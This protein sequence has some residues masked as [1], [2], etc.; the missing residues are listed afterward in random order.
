MVDVLLIFPP[1]S[2]NERYAK[3][4]GDVGG[5]LPPLGL[6]TIAAVLEENG[7]S[8][9][10][11]DGPVSGLD[12]RGV[13]KLA[14]KK[15]PGIIG[16]SFLTASVYRAEELAKYLKKSMPDTPVIVGGHHTTIL[17]KEVAKNKHFDAGV[18]GE[19]EFTFL[20]L[21]QKYKENPKLFKQPDELLKIQG[22]VVKVKGKVKFSGTRPPISDL[23]ALPF[24]ARHLVD[25]KKYVPLPNQYL[26]KPITNMVAIRGCPYQCTYC[27]NSAIFG[28]KI[29]FPSPERTVSEMEHLIDDYGIREISFW[30][31]TFT[32]NKEW[33]HKVCDLI[34]KKKFDIIWSCYGRVNTVDLKLLRKMKKAGCWNIFYGLEAGDQKLLD[35]INK[36]ITLQQI[37]NAI[38]WTKQ[39]GIE[40]RGSFMLALPGETPE[41]ARKT[42]DF[43][44]EL[45]LD[46]AQFCITTP[47]PGTKL[48]ETAK[49]YGKLDKKFD[50]YHIWSPV[51][52][53]YGYKDK[54]EIE[55]MFKLAFRKFYMRPSYAWKQ[56]RKIKT[57]EDVRRN[58]KGL[59]LVLG[60][61]ES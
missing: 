55:K 47:F 15:K 29:R 56:F 42:I 23:D 24:P 58:L 36:N 31:D 33:L 6:L 19:G 39:A 43:A 48:Y 27:S 9:E 41:L 46:Y 34:I 49:K 26:R 25:M 35:I 5:H 4:V 30:D 44:C 28:R 16:I 37:R 14:K 50:E 53:P 8:V 32:V 61:T 3:N 11:I 21:I 38:R 17:P 40:S 12:T 59:R 10:V 13:A 45:D 2:V 20:E 22:M 60:M 54:E 51:F 52:V 1:I 57:M 18:M 7:Y